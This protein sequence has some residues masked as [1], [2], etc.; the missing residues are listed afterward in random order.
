MI[1]DPTKAVR[2]G[3]IQLCPHS[4]VQQSGI[5]VCIE[6]VKDIR[7]GHSIS[8]PYELNYG[9]PYEFICHELIRVPNNYVALLIVR[10]TFNRQG[11]FIT[12]GLYDN[13]FAGKVGGVL[14]IMARSIFL[15]ENQRIGQVIFM[16]SESLAQYDGQ[17]QTRSDDGKN[18]VIET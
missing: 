8:L 18:K 1:A 2:D 9:R 12:T 11:A 6:S 17:Y 10:S 5:D 15:D 13:G 7:Y 16:Q 3:W 4:K 14:H